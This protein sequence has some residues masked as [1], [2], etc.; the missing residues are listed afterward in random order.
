MDVDYLCGT[1]VQQPEL[2]VFSHHPRQVFWDPEGP[3]SPSAICLL[4][5][6]TGAPQW[7]LGCFSKYRSKGSP[8]TQTC[9][10]QLQRNGSGWA[11]KSPVLRLSQDWV[12]Q[13]CTGSFLWIGISPCVPTGV[14]GHPWRI[15]PIPST[16]GNS[17]SRDFP[18]L[19][20]YPKL[21]YGTGDICRRLWSAMSCA[22]TYRSTVD[23][24]LPKTSVSSLSLT[25]NLLLGWALGRIHMPIPQI[26]APID[27]GT[28]LHKLYKPQNIINQY[29]TNWNGKLFWPICGKV[30]SNTW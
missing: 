19:Q 8:L 22:T 3:S 6:L 14:E 29:I 11:G 18:H 30:K 27:R 25:N 2:L 12:P 13:T 17:I 7:I 15:S 23:S 1:G 9:P 20:M 21:G 4:F 26:L 16:R 5:P 24:A 28:S 10:P